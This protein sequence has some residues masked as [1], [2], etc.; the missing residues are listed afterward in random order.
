MRRVFERAAARVP[1]HE[2]DNPGR[3]PPR[4]LKEILE[5]GQF[6]EDDLM[7]EYLG[8]VLAS[9]R[10][11]T[12]RDD[13]AATMAALIGRLSVYELRTHYIVYTGARRYAA[14]SGANLGIDKELDAT[15][16]DLYM[17]AE[18]YAA[19]LD[20]SESEQESFAS[21]QT[22]ATL[23]LIREG[24]LAEEY[25]F[26][27][28]DHLRTYQAGRDYPAVGWILKPTQLGLLLYVSAFGGR[29]Y[30][31]F[32]DPDASFPEQSGIDCSSV[33]RVVD[34]PSWQQPPAAPSA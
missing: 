22:H 19:A 12:G 26:G 9:S 7:V 31:D 11:E 4:V 25:S 29:D 33:V 32:V 34:L 14:G 1:P 5:H 3:V 24:L 16:G 17:P 27:H 8:G 2:L 21:I 6:A 10:T 18:A 20:L 13:R 28:P 30:R 23:N 15:I